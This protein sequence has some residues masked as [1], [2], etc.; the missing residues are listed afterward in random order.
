MR[1]LTI[2][3]AAPVSRAFRVF[4]I[5]GTVGGVRYTAQQIYSWG[6]IPFDVGADYEVVKT[7]SRSITVLMHNKKGREVKERLDL[8]A[9]EEATQ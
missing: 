1:N 5:S 6:S 3:D 4:V 7:D 9:V 2:T 8:T